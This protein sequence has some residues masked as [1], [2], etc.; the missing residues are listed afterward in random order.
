[1]SPA[2]T[3]LLVGLRGP[4]I[5][6]QA[7]VAVI[8]SPDAWFDSGVLASVTIRRLNL[9]GQGIRGLAWI[10]ALAGYLVIS[11]PLSREPDAFRLWLWNGNDPAARPVSVPG[12]NDMAR[13]EGVTSALVGGI[14]SVLLVSDDGNRAAGRSAGHLLVAIDR[15][16]IG[17]QSSGID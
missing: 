3:Q 4:L 5:D 15:L 9:G 16:Q 1:M 7:V 2:G 13:A 14:P 12:L 8:A 17:A 6:G 10:P 11:G